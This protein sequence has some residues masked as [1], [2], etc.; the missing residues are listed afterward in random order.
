M[1]EVTGA[2]CLYCSNTLQLAHAGAGVE[3]RGF[4]SHGLSAHADKTGLDT[5]IGITVETRFRFPHTLCGIF[6]RRSI[7]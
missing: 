7:F 3:K 1:T 2:V 6:N 5:P 4:M